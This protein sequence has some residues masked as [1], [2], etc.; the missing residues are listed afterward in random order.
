MLKQILTFSGALLLCACATG[1]LRQQTAAYPDRPVSFFVEGKTQAAFKVIGQMDGQA[2]DGILT[3]KKTGEEQFDVALI[4]GGVY[5]VLSATVSPQ[6]V[7]YHYLFSEVDNALVRARIT[8]LLD[9]LC[10]APGTYV[11]ARSKNGQTR[12][13]YKGPR[14]KTLYTYEGGKYPVSAQTI[15]TLNSAEL[16][17][18]DYMPISADGEVMIPHELV[19][20]DGKITLELQLISLR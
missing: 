15:T 3:V 10:L 14:A 1:G 5:R 17:Y 8:Q 19:Y 13:M 12:V 9:L 16:T 4:A 2:T 11:Q 20:Q 18:S 6:A 7:T